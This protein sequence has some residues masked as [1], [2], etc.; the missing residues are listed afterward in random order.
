MASN[1]LGGFGIPAGTVL[2]DLLCGSLHT[3]IR[4][5]KEWNTLHSGA[6][7][8]RVCHHSVLQ[9]SFVGVLKKW[10]CREDGA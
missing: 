5:V 8:D 3:R 2:G 9:I 1:G 4:I 7:T 10:D 6:N